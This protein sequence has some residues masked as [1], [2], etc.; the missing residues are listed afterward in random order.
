MDFM[1]EKNAILVPY[2]LVAVGPDAF[3][4]PED[5]RWAQP[6]IEFAAKAM[7]ELYEDEGLR[8]QIGDQARTDVAAEF[9]M[10]RAAEFTRS[11]VKELSKRSL[12]RRLG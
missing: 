7:R 6:N 8:I 1:D 12:L 3:P 10:E 9:T 11:R 2:D 4:Y 5:S